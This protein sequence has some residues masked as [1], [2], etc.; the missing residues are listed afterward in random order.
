M[1]TLL[2]FANSTI[3]DEFDSDSSM[4]KISIVLDEMRTNI[5]A[6]NHIYNKENPFWE[7]EFTNISP[8]RPLHKAIFRL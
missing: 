7:N 6:S 2:D 4:Q 3:V 8:I 5:I 1:S